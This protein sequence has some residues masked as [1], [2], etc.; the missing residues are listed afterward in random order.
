MS[1]GDDKTPWT[2]Y[3]QYGFYPEGHE[4]DGHNWYPFTVEFR[5]D[6]AIPLSFAKS[7]VLMHRQFQVQHELD[8]SVPLTPLLHFWY[9]G[10]LMY[11]HDLPSGILP[12][13]RIID[14]TSHELF[15]HFVHLDGRVRDDAGQTPISLG[16]ELLILRHLLALFD[17]H[18]ELAWGSERTKGDWSDDAQLIVDLSKSTHSSSLR[19]R[20][21]KERANHKRIVQWARN[22]TQYRLHEIETRVQDS[23]S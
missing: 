15:S 14:A 12:F 17:R 5:L 20:A 13:L 10:K 9:R 11:G 1:Y 19:L 8:I 4:D 16:S 7:S 2:F 6:K 3:R 22:R 23:L 18:S 21:V